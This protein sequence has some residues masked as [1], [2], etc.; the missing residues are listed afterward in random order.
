MQ[1][2]QQVRDGPAASP[3]HDK[4][5]C[6]CIPL[7]YL[8]AY[9]K[10]LLM[11]A[12]MRED[13]LSQLKQRFPETMRLNE[14]SQFLQLP[15]D[16]EEYQQLRETLNA[17]V[18]EGVIYRSTRRRY[19]L[20]GQT[21]TTFDGRL[22]IHGFNGV[23]YTNSVN[24][25]KVH[26]KR[27]YLWTAMHGDDVRVK[28]QAFDRDEKPNG[29]IIRVNKRSHTNYVGKLDCNGDFNF[30][31]P[32]DEHVHVDFLIHPK[33]LKGAK[34]G[35]KIVGR[36]L[37]WDDPYKSPEAE[38][39]EV[40]GR[41]GQAGVEFASI[42][43]EFHLDPN[44]KPE[45]EAEA[46][47][48]AKRVAPAEIQRR[49]DM[50]DA[51]I[52]TI[53]PVDARDFDDAL[54]L[55]TLEDG[56]VRLGVHIA[57]VSHYVSKNSQ[58][59]KE[60]LKRGNSVYLVDG[61]IPMLPETLSNNICSLMPNRNRLA[62]SVFMDISA[63]GAVR[64]YEIR[65]T[66]IRSKKRFT[67]EEVQ[68]IIEGKATHKY[69]ELIM[70]LHGL[71]ETLRKKRYARG[72]I[73]FDTREIKF[74]LDE[75]KQPVSAKLKSRTDATSLVEEC[76]LMANQT[77]ATHVKQISPG[78]VKKKR[79]L[80]FIYRIHDEPD[81]AKMA[82][83]MELVRTLGVDVPDKKLTSRDVNKIIRS[84]KDRREYSA[85][86][87]IMLRSMAKAVYS[88][89]NIGHYGLGFAD[90]S[91]FTSP[92]RRYPD[93]IV[94][95]LLKEYSHGIPATERLG[96]LYEAMDLISDQ[97]SAREQ[98]AVEAERAS[99][100]LTQVAIAQSKLG[101][102]FDGTVTGVT[103]FGLF[104]MIDDIYA[105]GL[106][107]VRDLDDDFYFFDE[108]RFSLIG[109]RRGRIYRI[110]TRMRIQVARVNVEK[111]EID[112]TYKGVPDDAE[113]EVDMDEARKLLA[114]VEKR[115]GRTPGGRSGR[116]RGGR[117]HAGGGKRSSGSR[118]RS[119]SKGRKKR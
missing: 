81:K 5:G 114:Q 74:S 40:L 53:D 90:Y 42:A 115:E 95:R 19:G 56:V 66:V 41:A 108:K 20:S 113:S 58:L 63:R 88:D 61:V 107:R 76:M 99:I 16:S 106:L 83:A 26:V 78:P 28:L 11:S 67:Y 116:R 102:I 21:E 59:D 38:I 97:C 12:K 110:G 39:V 23:V 45:I 15:S 62:Y 112:F 32:D 104:V 22:E 79:L 3:H 33:H 65:E 96:K 109:K 75:N 70:R 13:I 29:E 55:E 84:C 50:R 52:I 49:L 98:V 92:I 94:H 35:D 30:L 18:E 51:D 101:E 25:P 69:N 86:N 24:F 80:P 6:T 43:R 89:Y 31:I 60:A 103:N 82:D 48:V 57:D 8:P 77:V 10:D 54:S 85:I 72:G 87:Q 37:R 117:S 119:K 47:E 71:A 111:R 64:N 17:M 4:S 93:L 9:Y 118:G 105:E 91:H 14:L 44:F 73:D 7:V 34:D 36:L 68:D 1:Y 27:P 46:E 2:K 100:K